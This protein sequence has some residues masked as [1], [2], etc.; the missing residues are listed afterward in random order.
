[1]RTVAHA[2]GIMQQHPY[3]PRY[4][5]SADPSEAPSY[6]LPHEKI[7]AYLNIG[8]LLS[9]IPVI[10][11][12]VVSFIVLFSAEDVT[13]NFVVKTGRLTRDLAIP[14]GYPVT[15]D[16]GTE[17]TRL[18]YCMMDS[19]IGNDK[20][21]SHSPVVDFTD[22]IHSV[23]Y[24]DSQMD[25]TWPRDYGFLK[26]L[27][28]NF[29]VSMRQ[30]NVFL[31]CLDSSEGIM[32]EVFENMDSTYF[33]GTYNFVSFLLAAFAIMSSFVVATAGGVYRGNEIVPNAAKHIT[34]FNPL[35][36][37]CILVALVWNV[38]GLVW[39]VAMSFSSNATFQ[40]YPITIWTSALTI[41]TFALTTGF[42]LTYFVEYL[43]PRKDSVAPEP[44]S[45]PGENESPDALLLNPQQDDSQTANVAYQMN[46]LSLPTAAYR[47]HYPARQQWVG[48]QRIGVQNTDPLVE[49]GASDYDWKIITPLMVR[50]FGWCWVFTDGLLFVGMLQ[51][52]SS[53]MNS[54]AVRVYFGAVVARLMQLVS[55]YFANMAYINR[56][57]DGPKWKNTANPRNFGAHMVTLFTYLASIPVLVDSVYHSWWA[58]SYADQAVA[59]VGAK[60]TIYSFV[61]LV[62]LMPELCRLGLL[63]WV[64]Y[65]QDPGIGNVLFAHEFIFLWDWA[66]RA[67]MVTVAIFTASNSLHDA[68]SSLLG[69]S[70]MFA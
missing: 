1:M 53:I 21:G 40:H 41:G 55:S 22:C 32:S 68:Q 66:L 65:S 67:I 60:A 38:A 43:R 25:M 69:F 36:W 47:S 2:I 23:H 11:T 15:L 13:Q 49:A 62:V 37:I 31:T 58:V 52:Q 14:D 34:G 35:S 63:I 26:C 12:V 48:R 44:A 8:L 17:Y 61:V 57:A 18:Y 10:F 30:T 7:S 39:S 33:L 70:L 20:C 5:L 50:T 4:Y 6:T 59:G 64:S 24:C 27:Q 16:N 3:R 54:Y 19:G 51:P 9:A 42:F 28:N 56:I 45:A 29:N 46:P